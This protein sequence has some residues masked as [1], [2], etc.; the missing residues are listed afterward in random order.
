MAYASISGRARTSSRNPQAHAICDRCGCRYNLKDLSFQYDWRGP[1]LQNLRILVCPPCIDT[2]QEQLRTIVLPADPVP[3][4]NARPQDFTIASTDY[5][6][7]SEPPVIDPVTGIPIPGRTLRI[8]E[9]CQNRTLLPFGVPVGLNP[10][11]VMPLNGTVTYGVQLNLV[12]VSSNGS[13]TV[14]VTCGAVH[15]LQPNYQVSVSGL[16]DNSADGFY[17]VTVLTATAF[18]YMTYGS[19]NANALLTPT[20]RIITCLIGLPRGYEVIPKITGPSLTPGIGVQVCFF[21][22]ESGDG[23]FFL[24]DGSGFLQLESCNNFG[25]TLSLIEL[26]NQSGTVLLEDSSGSIA[27]EVSL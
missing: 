14:T 26:E 24:E 11:T 8:T 4:L 12:S 22:Q 9:D 16:A 13:A 20:T 6:T 17:S 18:T 10:N 25:P 1:V 23:M 5:R 3:V 7:I 19:I 21:E 27:L 2:P 15:N